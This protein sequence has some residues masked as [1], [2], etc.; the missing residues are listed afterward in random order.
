MDMIVNTGGDKKEFHVGKSLCDTVLGESK[1]E[2]KKA[3]K[4][5]M[6]NIP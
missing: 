5:E 6:R 3:C 2:T 1:E 4:L